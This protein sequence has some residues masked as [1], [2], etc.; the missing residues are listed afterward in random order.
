[1]RYAQ[2]RQTYV[3]FVAGGSGTRMGGDVPKQFLRL[4]GKTVL[5]RT[6]ERFIEAVPDMKAVTVL[7]KAHFR[8]WK[9]ICLESPFDFP[10]ILVEG[11]ITRFQSVR[12]ALDKVP[13]GAI[14]MIHDG[15]RPFVSPALI[16]RL[17]EE[18]GESGV[19]AIPV[20]PVTDTLRSVCPGVP[21]P[22]RSALV[23]VQTPQVFLSEDIRKAYGRAYELS[24]TDDASVAAKSGIDI[25]MVEGEKFNIKITTPED[26]VAGEAILSR[27]RV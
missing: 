17:L 2:K 8:T 10:Q 25:R 7:P 3:V 20:L 4:G 16:T 11:G 27:Q 15:V 23:A 6:M 21:D 24:F 13:D 18:V 26:L 14:V 1:M 9:N 5:Q 12:N 22:D 19:G